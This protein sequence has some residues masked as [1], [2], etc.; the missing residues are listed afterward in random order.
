MVS[1]CH[2]VARLWTALWI[3]VVLP[4]NAF[5][6]EIFSCNTAQVSR[7]VAASLF[8]KHC[9]HVLYWRLP[10]FLFYLF[11]LS[12]KKKSP[13][14]QRSI[15]LPLRRQTFVGRL[16]LF[17]KSVPKS[18]QNKHKQIW[19]QTGVTV[20]GRDRDLPVP[21]Q[22]GA[23]CSEGAAHEKQQQLWSLELVSKTTMWNRP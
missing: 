5:T 1:F 4:V 17:P 8:A 14:K 11:I 19:K 12:C 15:C 7:L 13:R 3:N 22:D 23:V 6:G 9:S 2:P 10:F 21:L 16:K 20:L 18:V